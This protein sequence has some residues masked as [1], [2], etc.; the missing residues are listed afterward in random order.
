MYAFPSRCVIFVGIRLPLTRYI[1]I[2]SRKSTCLYLSTAVFC[3]LACFFL[4]MHINFSTHTR[5]IL[6]FQK[7]LLV[8]DHDLIVLLIAKIFAGE[9]FG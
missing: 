8:N 4:Y 6:I 7:W 3:S 1:K 5:R 2:I 9:L